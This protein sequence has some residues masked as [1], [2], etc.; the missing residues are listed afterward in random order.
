MPKQPQERIVT[1]V[2]TISRGVARGRELIERFSDRLT[3][4]LGF[5]P[6][7]GTLDVRL[8]QPIDFE[9]YEVKRLEH[10]L[11][12]GS[13]WIDARLAPVKL[14]VNGETIDAW[15]IKEEKGLVE[16]D[17]LEILAPYSI[18]EKFGVKEGDIIDVEMVERP[19][20]RTKAIRKSLKQIFFPKIK[21]S[22][23]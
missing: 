13:L 12:E 23:K 21:R 22:I 1:Y 2:G 17:M 16:E 11:M 5:R 19:L 4:I 6:F 18:K 14:R 10:V 15:A 20:P 8:E 7:P 3:G 9:L